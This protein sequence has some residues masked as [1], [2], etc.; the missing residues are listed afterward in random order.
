VVVG[1]YLLLLVEELP[2]EAESRGGPPI[3]SMIAKKD[4][5]RADTEDQEFLASHHWILHRQNHPAHS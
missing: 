5:Q 4:Q 2:A 1:W 3:R